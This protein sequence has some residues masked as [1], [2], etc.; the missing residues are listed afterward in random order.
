M[1]TNTRHGVHA[2]ALTF[3]LAVLGVVVLM[4]TDGCT[5]LV[6]LP[7]LPLLFLNPI[8]SGVALVIVGSAFM[9]GLKFRQRAYSVVTIGVAVLT[10]ACEVY[11]HVAPHQ[12]GP[13]P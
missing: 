2:A 3:V 10:A 8:V 13:Y 6:L 12:C 4:A 7:F 1:D 9:L 5:D 11:A